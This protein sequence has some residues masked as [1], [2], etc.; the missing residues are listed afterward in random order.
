MLFDLELSKLLLAEDAEDSTM[1]DLNNRH[2]LVPLYLRDIW[3]SSCKADLSELK[4]K[5]RDECLLEVVDRLLYSERNLRY[6]AGGY[7]GAAISL[8]SPSLVQACC[9]SILRV[10]AF[11]SRSAS[12]RK[13]RML[14][15]FEGVENWMEKDK[16]LTLHFGLQLARCEGSSLYDALIRLWLLSCLPSF[17][18]TSSFP[19]PACSNR[20]T[21]HFVLSSSIPTTCAETAQ[22][23]RF[24][25]PVFGRKSIRLH[26]VG[27]DCSKRDEGR[28]S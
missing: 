8:V 20:C 4:T 16:A 27:S 3:N 12:S 9:T 6:V 23:N 5:I 17:S 19:T 7:Y 11:T 22:C 21:K 28:L 18:C 14:W 25:S 1:R 2:E 15:L 26:C 13:Q 10:S 24:I